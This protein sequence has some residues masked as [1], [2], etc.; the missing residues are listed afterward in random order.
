[1]SLRIPPIPCA[2]GAAVAAC[3]ALAGPAPAA[4]TGVDKAII[5]TSNTSDILLAGFADNATV[6]VVRDGVTVATGKNKNDP[7]AAPPEGGV[8][9]V[10][11]G[12]LGGCWTGFTP[13]LLPGDE[14][15]VG[16]DST[17]IHDVTAT[18]LAVDGGQLVVRG[19]AVSKTGAPLPLDEVDAQLHSPGGR[20]SQGSSGGQFLS[21]Q[22]GDLGGVITYDAPGSTRWTARWPSLGA[23]DSAFALA[24][25]VVGAW[26]GP[27]AAP[28]NAGGEETD[29]EVGATPGPIDSCADSPYAPNAVSAH[30]PVNAATVASDLVVSGTA[31]PGVTAVRV[32]LTD[33]AGKALPRAATVSGRSWSAAFPAADVAGLAEGAISAAGAY[34]I[35]AGTF[36]GATTSIAKDTVAPAAPTASVPGGSY[37][38]AQSVA[39]AAE[40]G[41]TIRYTTDGSDPTGSSA[42]YG[43]P[44][45]VP[46]TRTLKATRSTRR[47]TRARSPR[48]ATR[49]R[50]RRRRRR[51][52]RCPGCTSRR[53][54]C[55]RG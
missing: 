36:H 7:A 30:D 52:P 40:S 31:Q 39:L 38:S 4:V 23:A 21:A 25:A 12:A 27:A 6:N 42:A 53:C 47:A 46:D 43:Q 3:A 34:K 37:G 17:V 5:V 8:N 32:T 49:S 51:A 24:G 14:I 1:M 20:F 55:A 50:R 2:L 19:T 22:N 26:T 44:I 9:S 10:H 11:A 15:R 35:T 33:S 16:T 18:P 28:A 29:Y 41:A 48:S 13:Q 54:A 45:D